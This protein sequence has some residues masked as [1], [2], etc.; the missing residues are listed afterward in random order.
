MRQTGE[1]MKKLILSLAAL[2]SIGVSANATVLAQYNFGTDLSSSDSSANSNAGD[3]T[4]GSTLNASGRVTTVGNGTPLGAFNFN[5]SDSGNAQNVNGYITFQVTAS[6]GHI[7][8]L[9][10]LTFAVSGFA[11][12]QWAVRSSLDNYTSNLVVTSTTGTWNQETVSLTGA[13]FQGLSSITF[14]IYGWS[15]NNGHNTDGYI[16]DVTLNGTD[17]NPTVPEPVNVALVLFGCTFAGVGAGRKFLKKK[18]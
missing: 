6:S 18:A 14:R 5:R 2:L 17:T 12:N 7:L 16:D 11:V 3:I 13:N 9:Q 15:G 1:F 10:N 8:N 4:K